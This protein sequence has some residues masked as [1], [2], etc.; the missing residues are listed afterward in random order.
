[1]TRQQSKTFRLEVSRNGTKEQEKDAEFHQ[2]KVKLQGNKKLTVYFDSDSLLYALL[3][4]CR[5]SMQGRKHQVFKATLRRSETGYEAIYGPKGL[6]VFIKQIDPKLLR[7]EAE[8]E[9]EQESKLSV[10][11]QIYQAV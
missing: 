7:I 4:F 11:V 3:D 5:E 1:M 2:L 6:K 8:E 10:A 9:I